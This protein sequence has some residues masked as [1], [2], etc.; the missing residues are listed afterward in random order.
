MAGAQ[1]HC[2]AN[3]LTSGLTRRARE[4]PNARVKNEYVQT[5]QDKATK[6]AEPMALKPPDG[7]GWSLHS[8]QIAPNGWLVVVWQRPTVDG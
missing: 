8:W 2:L 7:N 6:P 4:G 1:R 5:Y 3:V